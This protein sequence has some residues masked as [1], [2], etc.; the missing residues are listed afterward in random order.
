MNQI[1]NI[2]L[3]KNLN[4]IHQEKGY[5]IIYHNLHTYNNFYIHHNNYSSQ[6]HYWNSHQNQRPSSLVQCLLICLV[7]CLVVLLY[8]S[9]A[10]EGKPSLP[11]LLVYLTY[12]SASLGT[13]QCI[14]C[15]TSG[16][17]TPMPNAMVAITTRKEDGEVNSSSIL[18]FT[19]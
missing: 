3:K 4:T 13:P 14:T 15:R 10:H 6:R 19:V 2:L 5:S 7:A 9:N 12:I 16:Q 18:S 11:A 17:S 1:F 8:N